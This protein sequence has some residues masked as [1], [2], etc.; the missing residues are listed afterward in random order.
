[1]NRREK[2]AAWFVALPKGKKFAASL[3]LASTV[4]AGPALIAQMLFA[5]SPSSPWGE[6]PVRVHCGDRYTVVYQDDPIWDRPDPARAEEM[7]DRAWGRA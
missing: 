4:I 3:V 7:C 2:F 6:D 1:M 5:H